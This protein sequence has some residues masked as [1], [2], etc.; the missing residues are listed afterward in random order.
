[1]SPNPVLDN[2][3]KLGHYPPSPSRNDSSEG[4]PRDRRRTES[5]VVEE[6]AVAGGALAVA[7]DR[8]PGD[9]V[10]GRLLHR[11]G[12]D[13]GRD[14]QSGLLPRPRRRDVGRPP[15]PLEELNE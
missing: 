9:H 15:D 3:F 1:M 10:P 2:Y 6:E 11:A 8:V 4:R 12:V 5:P 7:G 13:L 14:L